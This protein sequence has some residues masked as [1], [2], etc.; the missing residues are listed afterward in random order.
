MKLRFQLLALSLGLCFLLPALAQQAAPPQLT[1]AMAAQLS[2]NVNR[3]VIVLMAH[4]D[5]GVAAM[6]D[7]APL[8]SELNRVKARHVRQFRMVN[9]V[10]ATVSSGELERLRSN[11]AVA[12]VFS[13]SVLRRPPGPASHP[14]SGWSPP[15]AQGSTVPPGA[16]STDPNAPLLEPEA[17]QVTHTDSTRRGALTARSLGFTGAGVTVGFIADGADPNNANFLRPNGQSV[18][19]DYQDFSGDGANAPTTGGES[20]I[21]ANAIAGQGTQVYNL[22][23]FSA[24]PDPGGCYIRIEGVA[25][26][27]SVV[28]LKAAPLSGYF[29][30]SSILQAIEYAVLNDHVD[31]LNESFGFTDFPDDAVDLVKEFDDAAV[32]LGTTV[33]VSSGDAGSTDTV[34]NPASDAN[35]IAVGASTTFRAYAQTNE[36]GAQQFAPRGWLDDN[37][38][39]LSS[40]GFDQSG[41]TLSLVAPGDLGWASCDASPNFS[42]CLN[43]VGQPSDVESAGG[44]SMAAPLTAGAAALVIQAYRATHGGA[45]PSPALVKTILLSTASDLGAAAEEE[46]A[47]LLNTYAAVR[48]A[49]SINHGTGVVGAPLVLSRNQLNLVAPVNT[50]Q[51]WSVGIANPGP[52]GEEVSLSG[53]TLGPERDVRNGSV[54]LIGAPTFVLNNGKLYN[55]QTFTFTVPP[56]A[57]RLDAAIAYPGAP[58][59]GADARLSLVDPRG[60]FAAYSLP[61]GQSNFANVDVR[62]PAP[63]KWTGVIFIYAPYSQS[64]LAGPVTWQVYTQNYARFGSVWPDHFYLPAHGSQTVA[65][66]AV[67]PA[68]AG[69]A[70]GSI[71]IASS[72]EGYDRIL[73][74]E[75][76][77]IPVTLRSLIDLQGTGDF[78][79]TLTGGNGRAPNQGQQSYYQFQVG[80]GHGTLTANVTL[81]TDLGLTIG[82]YLVAPNG[83]LAAMAENVDSITGAPTPS[84]T[85]DCIHP[86]PGTWTLIVDFANIVGGDLVTQPFSGNVALDNVMVSAPGLPSSSH[87]QLAARV[88]VTIPVTITNPGL[89]TQ[90]VFLDARLRGQ[91]QTV[92]LA[93]QYGENGVFALPLPGQYLPPVFLV[94]SET[95]GLLAQAEATAPI[96]FDFAP[97]QGDP[98]LFGAPGA[99][100]NGFPTASGFYSPARGHVQAGLWQVTPAEIGP[101]PASGVPAG[102]VVVGM[103]ASTKA[104]D[105]AMSSPT[106]DFWLQALTGANSLAAPVDLQPGQSTTINVTI[107]P[108]APSG[109][110]VK[111]IL[112]VD[113][114]LAYVVPYNVPG[115]NELIALRY[116][117]TVQ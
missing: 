69:D 24:Q 9:A 57:A 36:G 72:A 88:P 17:L 85:A 102:E 98:D 63:G 42:D 80:R 23:Q 34:G 106:G 16:C 91:D 93:P 92:S 97:Y 20:F 75:L 71:V 58:G 5:T 48:L 38:S 10:A 99:L 76:A 103:L 37:I 104:F 21:D 26:G 79:G 116:E 84:L 35:V 73:G 29:T 108:S 27:A 70:A 107:T 59:S 54:N 44:T 3:Q 7:Q 87:T 15:S 11:P 32:A 41:R 110:V 82:A 53:R 77:S 51:T 6:N 67:T 18:F 43:D 95:K 2:Q 14:N 114:A 90:A 111:G 45:S 49:E 31:V 61:Q 50:S 96:E 28:G 115:G 13:D 89:G 46:G 55:Y 12:E 105:P 100:D 112:Y 22:G 52:T 60:R 65:V 25:P 30:V 101:F 113:S 33:T 117:Y 94:P 83:V 81:P 4:S 56:G 109:T 19:V 74:P 47:G 66:S 68:A 62:S 39:A 78:A 86:M 64:D 1:D 8:M 40:S